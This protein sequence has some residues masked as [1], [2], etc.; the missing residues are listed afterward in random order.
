MKHQ[1][2]KYLFSVGGKKLVQNYEEEQA[3]GGPARGWYESRRDL[4]ASTG[5]AGSAPAAAAAPGA[6]AVRLPEAVEAAAKQAEATLKKFY[7]AP[8]KIVI[9]QVEKM[10]NVD[11]LTE[12]QQIEENRPGGGR[13]PVL[14]AIA[15]RLAA[16]QAP[17]ADEAPT[18]KPAASTKQQE[19]AL[20]G[21]GAK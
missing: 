20:V 13:K 21:A 17:P 7:A 10:D 12:V 3:L 11:D 15:T 16:M 5:E 14:T 6:V 18:S 9:E 1:Y 8:V 4:P 19:P 2:P